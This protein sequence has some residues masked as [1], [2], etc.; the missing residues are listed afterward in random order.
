VR[1][2]CLRA[3]GG[4][5]LPERVEFL[6]SDDLQTFRPLLTAQ[7]AQGQKRRGWYGGD[8]PSTTARYLRVLATPGG[9]WTFLDEVLVNGVEPAA[10]VQHAS[11][12]CSATLAVQPNAYDWPG[13]EG[14]TDGYVSGEA[15]FLSPEWLGF[16]SRPFEATLDLGRE[17]PLTAVVVSCLQDVGA[18]IFV[19]SA[20]EILVSEDGREFE[21]VTT[22]RQAADAKPKFLARVRGEF[23]PRS[24]RYVRVRAASQGTWLFVDE[25]LVE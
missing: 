17:Q 5:A 10:D 20:V 25:V 22:V 19:P 21:S 13:V 3:A 2:H 15:N 4:V 11:V 14:L 18:G 24:A 7:L 8:T 12:G 16:E 6:V 1:V 23:A 9:D